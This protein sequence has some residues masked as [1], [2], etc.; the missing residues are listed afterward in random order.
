[1]NA[2]ELLLQNIDEHQVVRVDGGPAWVAKL[3]EQVQHYYPEHLHCHGE[4]ELQGLQSALAEYLAVEP[5]ASLI[6]QALKTRL[7]TGKKLL[8]TVQCDSVDAQALTYLLGLPSICDEQG[9]AVI[10]V[11][12]STPQ[13]VSVLKS[14]SA[15]A[16]KLDGYYQEHF[17]SAVSVGF[18]VKQKVLAGLIVLGI[19]AAT[20]YGIGDDFTA[21]TPVATATD[22]AVS[23]ENSVVEVSGDAAV[24]LPVVNKAVDA[25]L[26]VDETAEII[27]EITEPAPVVKT[28]DRSP[29]RVITPEEIDADPA[30]VADLI[31]VV[32]QA[33]SGLNTDTETVEGHSASV[34]NADKSYEMEEA[35]SLAAASS[36]RTSESVIAKQALVGRDI[37][38]VVSTTSG[39]PS[40]HPPLL[41]ST[42]SEARAN[43]VTALNNEEEVRK[44]FGRWHQAWQSQ[45]WD[46]YIDSY[47]QNMAPYGVDLPVDEWRRFRKQRLLSPEWIKLTFGTPTF[48]RLN[49]HWYRVEFYQ[50][51][52][53]PGYADETTKRLELQLTAEGWRIA[54]EAANGTVVLKRP[55]PAL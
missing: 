26:D 49:S 52:E 47:I 39:K 54:S 42:S 10:I 24:D 45:N 35:A 8:I 9:V 17:D 13:L 25:G 33:K 22:R 48:T 53:K 1:M 16:A 12:V 46:L 6:L 37:L 5:S 14:H 38:K 11:L 19:G 51:F 27:A 20:W 31:A 36:A 3:V 29:L 32:K 55:G 34:V 41:E 2:S 15:L 21:E 18:S 23:P 40:S 7:A 28:Q 44:V 30:L 43:T 4:L 50:R